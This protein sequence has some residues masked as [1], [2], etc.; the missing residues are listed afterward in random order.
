MSGCSLLQI[1]DEGAGPFFATGV[2]ES[3]AHAPG[4]PP[5]A[6]AADRRIWR[7]LARPENPKS[8]GNSRLDAIFGGDPGHPKFPSESISGRLAT[9]GLAR[10]TSARAMAR[11]AVA[12]AAPELFFSAAALRNVQHGAWLQLAAVALCFGKRQAAALSQRYL[13]GIAS[14]ASQWENSSGMTG[15][16]FIRLCVGGRGC[17][18][19]RSKG[20]K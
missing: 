8:W 3:S 7:Y 19:P 12:P 16:V 14:S 4:D 20:H 6:G 15:F 2:A 9:R 1:R 17:A 5:T 10:R 18:A 11:P 13:K